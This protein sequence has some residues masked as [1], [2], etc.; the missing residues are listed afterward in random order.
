VKPPPGDDPHAWLVYADW[1]QASP[2]PHWRALGE[3]IVLGEAGRDVDHDTHRA[4][5]LGELASVPFV[6]LDDWRGGFPRSL[7]CT[8]YDDDRAAMIERLLA[9]RMTA[10][11]ELLDVDTF[12]EDTVDLAPAIA[13][14]AAHGPRSLRAIVIGTAPSFGGPVR[15]EPARIGPIDALT[16]AFALEKLA[17]DGEQIGVGTLV[18]PRL[19]TLELHTVGTEALRGLAAAE[20][21]ALATLRLRIGPES[22]PAPANWRDA[23]LWL[24]TVVARLPALREL[25][26]ATGH[27]IVE[28]LIAA[29]PRVVSAHLET[30]CLGGIGLADA[31]VPLL[32]RV[33]PALAHIPLVRVNDR[34]VRDRAAIP[35]LGRKLQRL[36]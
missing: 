16:G 31:H 14:I 36:H 15:A 22:Y 17:I 24:P 6:R 32:R 29:L 25:A 3:A 20:L 4:A 28:L 13:R 12:C 11:L 10:R 5:W 30:L 1:L 27:D 26:L 34:F 9:H 19:R 8:L 18:A 21:P 2:E 35:A 7:A 23:A 33:A